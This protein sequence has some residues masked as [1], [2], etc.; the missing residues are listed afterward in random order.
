M[1]HSSRIG[2]ALSAAATVA[3]LAGCSGGG[4]SVPAI[5]ATHSGASSQFI[6]RSSIPHFKLIDALRGRLQAPSNTLR[7]DNPDPFDPAAPTNGV[8]GANYGNAGGD[9]LGG[10]FNLYKLPGSSHSMPI[11]AN[12]GLNEVAEI[13]GMGVDSTGKLWVPGL[14]PTNLTSGIV[15]TFKKN[16]CTE[17]TAKL[18]DKGGE[19]ADIAFTT[20][21]KIFVL[22]IV[23]FP[24][25]TNGQIEVYPNGQTKPTSTLQLPGELVGTGTSQGLGLGVAT[26]SKNNVY[27]TYL[28]TSGGT[29]ITKFAGGKGVGKILQNSNGTIYEGMTFDAN[30]NL[31]VAADGS[32]GATINIFAP[33]FTGTPTSFAAQGSVVDLKLDPAGTNLYVGDAANNTIDVY[34]YPSGTYKYSIVVTTV[35]PN[36][37]VVEGVA[38]DPSANN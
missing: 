3:L 36:G 18:T 32:G 1:F 28:N 4:S 7:F 6:S 17:A 19:P 33:P 24:A 5:P 31:V 25:Q 35:P 9:Q 27:A 30:G 37:A 10:Y 20:T 21:G 11:C 8:Y 23:N 15:L 2:R 13:N 14:K 16:T 34:K 26:D 38:V 12:G 22:D 29:D